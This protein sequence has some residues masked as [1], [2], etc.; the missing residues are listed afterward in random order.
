MNS[1][2]NFGRGVREVFKRGETIDFRQKFYAKP[3]NTTVPKVSG[4]GTVGAAQSRIP[5]IW[6]P[7]PASVTFVWQLNGHTVGT[8]ATYTPVPADSG[9]VLT[10]LETAIGTNGL[11]MTARSPGVLVP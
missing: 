11:A 1:L 2:I 5:G 8:G 7:A 3:R 6:Q 10:I 4:S 9:K